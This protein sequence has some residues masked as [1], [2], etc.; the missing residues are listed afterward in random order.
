MT[1]TRDTSVGKR[2]VEPD[3]LA[4]MWETVRDLVLIQPRRYWVDLLACTVAGWGGVAAAV[5]ATAH[6]DGGRRAATVA[7]AVLASALAFYRSASFI[8]EMSHFG[9]RTELRWWVWGWRLLAGVP[10][11]LPSFLYELHTEHHARASYATDADGEYFAPHQTLAQQLALAVAFAVVGPV[12]LALRF[13]VV[14]PLSWVVPPIARAKWRWLSSLAVRRGYTAD[15]RPDRGSFVR[16]HWFLEEVLAFA[17]AWG[18]L[19]AAVA[20]PVA[21]TTVA[22]LAA[23]SSLGLLLNG[24]RV[25]GAHRYAGGG[26]GSRLDQFSDAIDYEQR[27]ALAELWAPTGLRF[28]AIHHLFPR[29]PYHALPEARRRLASTWDCAASTEHSLL[30]V[31]YRRARRRRSG[32]PEHGAVPR[33][34]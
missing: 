13:A 12:G 8:H 28:H 20:S 4:A 6:L 30:Q 18:A 2:A 7:L 33:S 24:L 3:Q 5:W 21:R 27:V 9:N 19:A 29:L 23:A 32:V 31:I 15:D 16:R 1:A 11:M 25:I 34:C 14:A 17:W 10:L 22:S 26:S